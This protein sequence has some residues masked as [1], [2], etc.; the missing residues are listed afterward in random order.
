MGRHA[1]AVAPSSLGDGDAKATQGG[2]VAHQRI[3]QLCLP[4]LSTLKWVGS[5]TAYP[6]VGTLLPPYQL[7]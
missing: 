7:P 5:S 6:A 3:A 1:S 2:D 4:R